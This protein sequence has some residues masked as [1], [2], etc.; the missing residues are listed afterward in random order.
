MFIIYLAYLS[1]LQSFSL[2][3]F[4]ERKKSETE[5]I[6]VVLNKDLKK[7]K[8]THKSLNRTLFNQTK[9]DRTRN[10]SRKS[11]SSATKQYRF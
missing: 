11:S 1:I 8:H 4:L 6:A 3:G 9:Q 10:F 5:T 2:I 7:K